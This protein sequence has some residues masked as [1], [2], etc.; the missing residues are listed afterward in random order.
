MSNS[1]NDKKQNSSSIRSRLEKTTESSVILRKILV[2]R[3]I[4]R[5]TMNNMARNLLLTLTTIIIMVAMLVSILLMNTAGALGNHI[6]DEITK[7]IT[8]SLEVS[9]LASQTDVDK[10]MQDLRNFKNVT[11]VSYISKEEARKEFE[12]IGLSIPSFLDENPFAARLRIQTS[13]LSSR[14]QIIDFISTSVHNDTVIITE[15]NK[16][17]SS[18][19]GKIETINSVIT[20]TQKIGATLAVLFAVIAALVIVITVRL[21]IHTR[22]D[23]LAIMQL[24][25][26]SRSSI[27][28]PFVFEGA[29]SG[30]IGAGIALALFGPAAKSTF[31]GIE[32]F[33][34][35]FSIVQYINS[36]ITSLALILIATGGGLGILASFISTAWYI[37]K[38]PL[39]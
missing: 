18:Y 36:E 35:G 24:V 9:E 22:R 5:T 11:S 29:L 32:N 39:I 28:G 20:S 14:K 33:F 27:I 12:N 10:L 13:D 25:G 1:S 4:V 23:E 16:L 8:I 30:L 7:R 31:P 17:N 34:E 15:K 6:K 37:R 21:T 26:A 19:E 38:Q 3:R 2:F